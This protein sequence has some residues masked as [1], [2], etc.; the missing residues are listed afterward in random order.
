MKIQ[1]DVTLIILSVQPYRADAAEFHT[2]LSHQNVVI[3]YTVVHISNDVLPCVYMSHSVVYRFNSCTWLYV[4]LILYH[5]DSTVVHISHLLPYIFKSCTHCS[6][7][8]VHGQLLHTLLILYHS[9]SAVVHI[10]HSVPYI[11]KIF[12][13]TH[14]SILCRFNSLMCKCCEIVIGYVTV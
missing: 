12:S 11:Y 4:Y 9:L 3:I 1:T 7:C 2:F 13:V 14:L 6:F 8:T 5:T 10:S